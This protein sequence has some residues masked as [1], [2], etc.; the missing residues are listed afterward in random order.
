VLAWL[1]TVAEVADGLIC[2]SRSVAD[3]LRA[4]LAKSKPLRLQSI[5]L[6]FFHLG[7]DLRASQPTMGL[8]EDAAHVLEKLRSRPSF[9][10][11]GTLEPRKGHRQTL[12][13]L[14]RLWAEGVDVN[15]VIVGKQGW[16]IDE[17]VRRIEHHP[18][19]RS[20]LLW[21]QAISDQM[22]EEIYRNSSALLAPSE[23][24]GFGLPLIEAAQYALPII[25]RDIPVFREV[26]GDHAY[27]FRGEDAQ[28][29][30]NALRHWLSLG[31]NIP[32]SSAIPRLTWH[33]SSRQLL[34]I[35]LSGRWLS[36]RLANL[37]NRTA[38][39]ARF[40]PETD[41]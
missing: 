28:S 7:A 35:V 2:I 34:E 8:S 36:S 41:A 6:G 10:V 11:V 9:L 5:S 23:G 33:Q 39:D 20:R 21:M 24:E 15:L 3:E 27:Y 40:L 32:D 38:P 4:W 19:Y 37:Q 17:L 12:A 1:N 31:R 18:E 30:A 13:A 26:A 29:L 14:E 25:A 22:L 16:R